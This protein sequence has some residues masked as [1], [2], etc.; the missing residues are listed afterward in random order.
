MDPSL[1]WDDEFGRVAAIF[2]AVAGHPK[3]CH[4]SH[5]RIRRWYC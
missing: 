2:V 1:R 4:S 5:S 3:A